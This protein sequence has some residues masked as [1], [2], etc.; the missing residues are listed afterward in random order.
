MTK[1]E[2]LQKHEDQNEYHFHQVDREWIMEA[3][4]EY[5]DQQLRLYGVVDSLTIKEAID[6]QIY[7]KRKDKEENLKSWLYALVFCIMFFVGLFA[8][9]KSCSS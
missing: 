3:M 4:Q 7:A 6:Y 5:A 9:L 1:D 8:I 2:I